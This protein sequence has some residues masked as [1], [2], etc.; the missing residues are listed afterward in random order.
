MSPSFENLPEEGHSEEEEEDEENE[1]DIDFS[2]LCSCARLA[3]RCALTDDALA[4]KISENNTKCG[5]KRVS[6]RSY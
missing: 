2:G 5:S 6:M 1:D 3:S 4:K